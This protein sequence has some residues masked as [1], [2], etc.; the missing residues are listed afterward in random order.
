MKYTRT[1]KTVRELS[2]NFF[3]L[4]VWGLLIYM[5]MRIEN[6]DVTFSF[7]VYS[8]KKTKTLK[9]KLTQ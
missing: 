2:F 8:L 1:H 7:I 4:F 3:N 5:K 9:F 6:Y